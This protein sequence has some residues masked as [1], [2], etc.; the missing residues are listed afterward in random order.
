MKIDKRLYKKSKYR[1]GDVIVYVEAN[2]DEKSPATILQ[3][4]IIEAYGYIELSDAEDELGWFYK[5]EEI[6]RNKGS[7]LMENDI[8][9]KL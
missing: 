2:I 9:Y 1:I 7:S 6:H 8:L 4:K 3:S 5:T